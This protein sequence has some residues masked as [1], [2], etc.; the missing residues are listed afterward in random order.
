MNVE[1]L[2]VAEIRSRFAF[3]VGAIVDSLAV[4]GPPMLLEEICA[5][6]HHRTG[7]RP[8]PP[9]ISRL[10]RGGDDPPDPT[11]PTQRLAVIGTLD[12]LVQESAMETGHAPLEQLAGS[13]TRLLRLARERD[14][15]ADLAAVLLCHRVCWGELAPKAPTATG[16]REPVE[17]GWV[18]SSLLAGIYL[19]PPEGSH[20]YG[21][22]FDGSPGADAVWLLNAASMLEHPPKV[23]LAAPQFGRLALLETG[24]RMD[25]RAAMDR[26]LRRGGT[27]HHVVPDDGPQGPDADLRADFVCWLLSDV[28]RG[29]EYRTAR[30]AEGTVPS[31][32]AV[33]GFGAVE[34]MT[35]VVA[36]PTP[37]LNDQVIDATELALE[38]SFAG[39]WD[40]VTVAGSDVSPGTEAQPDP[41]PQAP[42]AKAVARS[43]QL[44]R[45]V[46]AIAELS[47]RPLDRMSVNMNQPDAQL[48]AFDRSL[49]AVELTPGPRTTVRW[50]LPTTHTPS[51][52]TDRQFQRWTDV[53]VTEDERHAV[54]DMWG[55]RHARHNALRYN[56]ER[57]VYWDITSPRS[58]EEYLAGRSS[59]ANAL[60]GAKF[61]SR[62][63][64]RAHVQA[65]RDL[66]S[67]HTR[68]YHL[69][70]VD[71][72]QLPLLADRRTWWVLTSSP[73]GSANQ[74]HLIHDPA[75]GTDA[76]VLASLADGAG[77]PFDVA[78]SLTRMFQ[79]YLD[80]WSVNHPEC[81]ERELVA[82]RLEALLG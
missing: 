45:S 55:L 74:V 77:D 7:E 11:S 25:W 48:A 3:A 68:H 4:A 39:R 51:D 46:D 23:V 26:V 32:V 24:L 28:Q 63:E 81:V 62:S 36:T 82:E 12:S 29:G 30:R 44:F 21:L 9:V 70:L 58:I 43:K 50:G 31:V 15:P 2:I 10:R 5:E 22:E 71:Q 17:V 54:R 35:D 37:E 27:V 52:I 60:Y 19:N 14:D 1:A 8:T 40:R 69:A 42:Q 67:D 47:R 59:A 53:C 80:D 76:I 66:L 38:V 49:S 79:L 57:Y 64:R 65:V 61:L 16:G 72:V 18:P 73:N 56:I 34:L 6:A 78:G 20:T 33:D 13:A 75:D 41:L